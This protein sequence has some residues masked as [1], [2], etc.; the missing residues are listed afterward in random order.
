M[1]LCHDLNRSWKG[2]ALKR[3]HNRS[4]K[5]AGRA[6]GLSENHTNKHDVMF[7]FELLLWV[8]YPTKRA[9][10]V[11]GSAQHDRSKIMPGTGKYL[12]SDGNLGVTR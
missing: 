5:R 4:K 3:N 2:K 12:W 9:R 10:R 8:A 7:W 1:P 11:V 6:S